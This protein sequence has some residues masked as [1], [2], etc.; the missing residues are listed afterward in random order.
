TDATWGSPNCRGKK[1]R[2]EDGG[3]WPGARRRTARSLEHCIGF[4]ARRLPA[5]EVQRPN[6]ELHGTWDGGAHDNGLLGTPT[7]ARDCLQTPRERSIGTSSR[8]PPSRTISGTC[9]SLR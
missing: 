5:K 2:R 9:A 7:P 6:T 8:S 1:G 3:V 4:E